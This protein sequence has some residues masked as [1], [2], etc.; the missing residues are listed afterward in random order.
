VQFIT[1][2]KPLNDGTWN[3]FIKGLD[4]LN[5]SDWETQANQNLKDGGWF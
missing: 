2:Q 5:V 4:N 3:A 1:G